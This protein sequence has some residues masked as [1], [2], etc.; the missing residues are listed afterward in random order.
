MK[1]MII[2]TVRNHHDIKDWE[3]ITE[4]TTAH[5][6]FY[7]FGNLE[8]R[9]LVET[10]DQSLKIYVLH[11][12][13][14][15]KALGSAD[16]KL[17]RTL[18]SASLT[19][20]L[21]QAVE[22]AKL[23]DNKPY[24]RVPGTTALNQQEQPITSA[25]FQLLD[26]VAKTY[27]AQATQHA[28]FNQLEAFHTTKE[29]HLITS[30]GCDYT[31]T[32]HQVTVEAIPTYNGKQYSVELYKL[33]TYKTIDDDEMTTKAKAA[34]RDV[35]HRYE[36]QTP[37]LPNTLDVLLPH[38]TL[39]QFFRAIIQDV[40]LQSL[41]QGQTTKKRGD[42]IQKN[43]KEDRISLTLS[44]ISP[45]DFFD[46]EGV[47]L[48][49]VSVL[50]EGKLMNY[51][52]GQQYASYCDETPSGRLRKVCVAPGS[53]PLTDLKSAP[54]LDIIALSGLQIEPYSG[55]IGGEIRLA[56][57]DDGHTKTPISG[58]SFSGNLD[59]A[60]S[61]LKMSQETTNQMTY[62]GPTTIKLTGMHIV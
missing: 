24:P 52:G 59:E 12:T 15:H 14:D 21:N 62:Q 22:S 4:T 7:A 43:P 58:I 28:T 45:A 32:L 57:Y 18:S 34:L 13:G 61:Q 44:P 30:T 6:A 39:S 35:K 2:D 19:T 23:V 48:K 31:K 9:R 8:T 27:Q 29:T 37:P 54:H 5:E 60:L 42:M 41:Y 3:L 53:Y 51:I 16:I 1:T 50:S 17:P 20:L 56:I 47:L 46:Q 11:Q 25:P 36:A 55:Y 33:H 10:T 40:S 49:P 26:A 38:G